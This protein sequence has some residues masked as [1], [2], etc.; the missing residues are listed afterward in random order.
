[1]PRT[2]FY[3]ETGAVKQRAVSKRTHTHTTDVRLAVSKSEQVGRVTGTPLQSM[4]DDDT[5]SESPYHGANVFLLFIGVKHW[6]CAV[7][8]SQH[9]IEQ[10]FVLGKSLPRLAN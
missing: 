9:G 5:R 10:Q 1:M 2:F 6:V 7:E 3:N 8:R 4:H